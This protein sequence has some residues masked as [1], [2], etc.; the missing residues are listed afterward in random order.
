[1][2]TKRKPSPS[3]LA[4][5]LWLMA[6]RADALAGKLRSIGEDRHAVAVESAA[7][8]FSDAATKLESQA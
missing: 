7:C 8:A 3:K 5:S 2:T 1:M 4:K 6:H